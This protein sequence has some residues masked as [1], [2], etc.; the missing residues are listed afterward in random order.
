MKSVNTL[1][2]KLNW[3][4][5]L[6]L[7]VII[8]IGAMLTPTPITRAVYADQL[9]NSIST[10]YGLIMIT[11]LFIYGILVGKGFKNEENKRT[12]RTTE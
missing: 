9:A 6:I 10:L 7:P 4:N 1:I 8:F 3:K 11:S 12:T 2:E 5:G